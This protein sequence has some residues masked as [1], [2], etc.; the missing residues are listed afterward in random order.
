MTWWQVCLV[1]YAWMSTITFVLYGVDKRRARRAKPRIAES[2]LHW[3]AFLG[4]FP[5]AILAMQFFHHKSRKKRFLLVFW[6]I[7]LVHLVAWS[8]IAWIAWGPRPA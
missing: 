3:C 1:V 7:V 2:T 6:T 4:G 5:G 8:T